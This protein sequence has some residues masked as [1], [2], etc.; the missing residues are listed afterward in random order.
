MKLHLITNLFA[1]DELAGAALFTDLALFFRDA[2]FDI[3]VTT[4]F[5]YYPAWKLNPSDAG[6]AL[7]EETFQEIPVRRVSMRVPERVT[8]AT[9]LVSDASFLSSL[10]RRGRF[11]GW[12]PDVVLTASPMFSQC[13]AQR[14]LY[15]GLSIPRL[16]VVQDFVVDA[17]LELGIVRF[18]GFR[19]VFLGLEKWAFN[20][21]STLLTI[22][23]G[24]LD[25]LRGKVPHRRLRHV[26]NWIHASLREEADRQSGIHT[27]EPATLLYAGNLGRK[28]GLPDFVKSFMNAA[29]DW[30]LQIHGGGAEAAGLAESVRDVPDISLGGVLDETDYVRELCRASACLVTQ[31]SGVGANFFP[32]KLLPA[33]A[34][35]TPVLAVCDAD[36][37]LA[38]EVTEGGYGKVIPPGDV[39]ALRRA[40]QHWRTS[41]GEIDRLSERAAIRAR[42]YS[43]ETILAEYHSEITA[44]CSG[45]RPDAINSS[46]TMDSTAHRG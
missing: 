30:R 40:F 15:P 3:R 23:P 46:P 41:P 29:T 16:I 26:P 31:K 9:R 32:S 37:P 34:A 8:G 28:Q 2:G 25:K 1:P 35:G 45:S 11:P 7:R 36:S 13:L 33:L 22:S 42:H 20:S 43:R 4:T 12:I 24:M 10:I 17:A 21:A 6:V 38:R 27:R 44:L 14:F 5:P 18:P 19:A 39:A